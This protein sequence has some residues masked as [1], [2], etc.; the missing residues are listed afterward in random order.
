MEEYDA[1][2]F[3][4]LLH[5]ATPEMINARLREDNC[6][7]SGSKDAASP[8]AAACDMLDLDLVNALLAKGAD[9]NF[10]ATRKCG[11]PGMQSPLAVAVASYVFP[12][13][14]QDRRAQRQKENDAK[15]EIAKALLAAGADVNLCKNLVSSVQGNEPLRELLI[16]HGALSLGALT[17]SDDKSR[18]EISSHGNRVFPSSEDLAGILQQ[19][20]LSD[21]RLHDGNASLFQEV[22]GTS[23]S[24]KKLS[25]CFDGGYGDIGDTEETALPLLSKFPRLEELTW[26]HAHEWINEHQMLQLAR[27]T[28][29]LRVLKLHGDRDGAE[30]SR[31]ICVTDGGVARLSAALPLQ[32]LWV[33]SSRFLARASEPDDDADEH[34]D[35]D[36]EVGAFDL[37]PKALEAMA[38]HCPSLESVCLDSYGVDCFYQETEGGAK[39]GCL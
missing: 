12:G 35:D 26:I 36:W 7:V 32:S 9:P 34:F 31:R 25:C 22:P 15:M 20:S 11:A 1:A 21:L 3:Y 6:G 29:N 10:P 24:V 39:P 38:Q 28:P 37:S 13:E 2:A 27:V 33:G 30:G 14:S 17:W 5:S 8:L 23:E 4:R 16:E 18:A 19:Q